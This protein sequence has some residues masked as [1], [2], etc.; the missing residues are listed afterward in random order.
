MI[1]VVSLS[2]NWC[3]I[4]NREEKGK[5]GDTGAGRSCIERTH[6]SLFFIFLLFAAFM[7]V[8]A[9]PKQCMMHSNFVRFLFSCESTRRSICPRPV[10]EA[11]R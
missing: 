3:D 10:C 1:W 6:L 8:F 9:N 7:Y 5:G 11:V 4:R 2:E